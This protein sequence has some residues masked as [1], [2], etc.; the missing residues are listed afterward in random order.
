MSLGGFQAPHRVSVPPGDLSRRSQ[1]H[2]M[3]G[4]LPSQVIMCQMISTWLVGNVSRNVPPTPEPAG[5]QV[6][7][8]LS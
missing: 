1:S 7:Q 5:Y 4:I 6:L 8:G 3:S 2:E